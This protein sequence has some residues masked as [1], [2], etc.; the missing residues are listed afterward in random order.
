MSRP[1]LGKAV[2]VSAEMIRRYEGGAV[3]GS[4]K[5]EALARALGVSVGALIDTT[6]PVADSAE[7]PQAP[8]AHLPPRRPNLRSLTDDAEEGAGDYVV[9][10][11]RNGYG[12]GPPRTGDGDPVRLRMPS[13]VVRAQ[14]GRL[15]DPGE[16]YLSYVVGDSMEPWLQEGWP[17]WIE[18]TGEV[19]DTGRYALCLDGDGEV[20]RRVARL[21]A[22]R[23]RVSA[24]NGASGWPVTVY[25][26]TGE[27]DVW[28]DEHGGGTVRLE[29]RGRVLY[30]RDT[31]QAMLR[32][33]TDQFAA[34]LGS[35]LSQRP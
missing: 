30:P 4:D 19:R 21:G 1:D 34:A 9:D 2:G 32:T 18:R 6:T 17:V 14:L 7:Q 35:L 5:L 11:Y 3:P 23:L 15:P 20:I 8:A 28:T 24:D 27:A 16:V 10:L 26:H 12:A 25:R 22:G 31:P 29:V 33:V 13:E